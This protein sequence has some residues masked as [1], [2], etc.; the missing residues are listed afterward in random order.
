MID[1]TSAWPAGGV[2][3]WFQHVVGQERVPAD[4]GV[5]VGRAGRTEATVT[6]MTSRSSVAVPRSFGPRMCTRTPKEK[7]SLIVPSHVLHRTPAEI[8]T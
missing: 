7:L 5:G 4:A 1:A 6:V 8:S 2:A 3:R